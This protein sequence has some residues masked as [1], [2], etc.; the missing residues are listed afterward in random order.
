MASNKL[1]KKAAT[2]KAVLAKKTAP[3]PA[4]AGRNYFKQSEFPLVEQPG[5]QQPGLSRQSGAIAWPK[6][7]CGYLLP[8]P[9]CRA[10]VW[11]IDVLVRSFSSRGDKHSPRA[12]GSWAVADNDFDILIERCK[13][14]H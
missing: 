8:V 2:K 10:G 14:P 4:A 7:T 1:T 9:T 11:T 12:A 3:A 6:P 13:E 5:S